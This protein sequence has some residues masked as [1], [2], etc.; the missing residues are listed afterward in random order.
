LFDV[1]KDIEYAVEKEIHKIDILFLEY[2][3]LIEKQENENTE[4]KK[5]ALDD[6]D[7]EDYKNEYFTPQVIKDLIG[8]G[9]LEQ[10]MINGK[11]KPFLRIKD[12][13]AWMSIHGYED[14]LNYN[15]I[16]RYIF[17]KNTENT[18]NQYLKPCNSGREKQKKAKRKPENKIP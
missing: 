18:I 2:T 14:Y 4:G 3:D 1:L 9:Q 13:I 11:Y 7:F 10:N 12:F 16:N 6:D 15:F 8:G 17:H 5:K